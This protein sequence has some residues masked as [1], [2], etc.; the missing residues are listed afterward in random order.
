[1]D[2]KL[3]LGLSGDFN[4]QCTPTVTGALEMKWRPTPRRAPSRNPVDV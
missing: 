2:S 4:I 3:L 1:M